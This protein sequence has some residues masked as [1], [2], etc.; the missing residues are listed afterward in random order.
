MAVTYTAQMRSAMFADKRHASSMPSMPE[1]MS[2]MSQCAARMDAKKSTT[3]GTDCYIASVL[4][5]VLVLLASVSLVD[6]VFLLSIISLLGLIL[7]R[8]LTR[9][10]G[11]ASLVGLNEKRAA[12]IIKGD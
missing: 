6:L 11:F 3:P 7:L 5:F 4:L 9:L 1:A 12:R 2:A 8:C 10:K